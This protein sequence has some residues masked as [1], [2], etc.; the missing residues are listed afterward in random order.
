MDNINHR[1]IQFDLLKV[2]AIFL[3]IY[4]HVLLHFS[5]ENYMLNGM[6]LWISTFHM[7]LFMT[8]SGFF[9]Y[10]MK[11]QSFSG[12]LCKRSRQLLLPCLSWSII[13]FSVCY[14]LFFCGACEA[15]SFRSVFVNSL[16]FLKSAFI[17]SLLGYFGIHHK[18]H[19]KEWII[20]SLIISQFILIYNVFIMYPCFVLGILIRKYFNSILRY[21]KYIAIISGV[22]FLIGSLHLSFDKTF[23]LQNLGIREA[24]FAG[25]MDIS[26]LGEV[27]V[28]R[29]IQ[30]FIGLAGSIFF[31]TFIFLITKKLQNPQLLSVF[32]IGG[33]YTLGIYVLQTVIL[34]HVL[35]SIVNPPFCSITILNFVYAPTLAMTTFCISLYLTMLISNRGGGF[36]TYTVWRK[37]QVETIL[38]YY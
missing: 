15:P 22:V 2:F 33:R 21:L 6:F 34:E 17:C 18:S 8:I 12:V 23:W 35:A 25:D 20:A 26:F 36:R 11:N 4:G 38:M 37:T 1:I 32:S 19:F 16:W 5:Q 28:K 14:I 7:P 27:I 31:I 3:V 24:L 10:S 9:A 13:I 29:Y 30:L